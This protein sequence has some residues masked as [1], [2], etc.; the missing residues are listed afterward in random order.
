MKY[1]ITECVS[2]DGA[3][4]SESDFQEVGAWV[5]LMN[6]CAGQENGG[7]V[8]GAKDRKD[9]FFDRSLKVPRYVLETESHLWKWED[10]DLI[11]QF[12]STEAED[13]YKKKRDAGKRGGK[14]KNPKAHAKAHALPT[15]PNQTP[16]N[17]KKQKKTQPDRTDSPPTGD[18]D[19]PMT[20]AADLAHHIRY[21]DDYR[22]PNDWDRS[23]QV[24]TE[25]LKL[26]ETTKKDG[27][28][29]MGPEKRLTLQHEVREFVSELEQLDWTIDGNP[30]EN[31]SGLF[32]HRMEKKGLLRKTR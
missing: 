22:A 2:V 20:I 31:S 18:D 29:P 32:L 1:F 25:L 23:E 5:F 14:K 21:A 30:V 8:V 6:Y 13:N 3:E 4:F 7:R 9:A 16:V 10:A 28:M 12:Y 19:P 17:K 11:V 26:I 27:E 15:K 24:R